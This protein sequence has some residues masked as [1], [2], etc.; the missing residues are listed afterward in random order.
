MPKRRADG[1][2]AVHGGCQSGLVGRAAVAGPCRLNCGH[3]SGVAAYWDAK[4]LSD[5]ARKL[6]REAALYVETDMAAWDEAHP[7]L[8][9]KAWLVDQRS[10]LTEPPYTDRL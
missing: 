10:V 7:P 1:R 2:L 6:A 3:R 8:T 9:F 5:E 4:V